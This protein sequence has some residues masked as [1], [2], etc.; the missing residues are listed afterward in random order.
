MHVLYYLLYIIFMLHMLIRQ[1]TYSS[2]RKTFWG[3]LKIFLKYNK[4]S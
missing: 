1:V 2:Y 4:Q 3:L